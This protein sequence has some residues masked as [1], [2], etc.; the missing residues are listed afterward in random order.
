[1][2]CSVCELWEL[3]Q[4]SQLSQ[5]WGRKQG[6]QGSCWCQWIPFHLRFIPAGNEMRVAGVVESFW[7]SES[8]CEQVW[9]EMRRLWQWHV[10]K[11]QPAEPVDKCWTSC[12]RRAEEALERPVFVLKTRT[13][14][15]RF[16]YLRIKIKKA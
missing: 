2:T 4:L 10:T 16:V 12:Q 7:N 6:K 15:P 14:E 1:M 8:L 9:H 5:L 11:Y 13:Q 3:S